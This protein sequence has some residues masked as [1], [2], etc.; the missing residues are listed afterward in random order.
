MHLCQIN[1]AL[2]ALRTVCIMQSLREILIAGLDLSCVD[3]YVNI[4]P[5]RQHKIVLIHLS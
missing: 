3:K 5:I 4:K 1:F 2:W